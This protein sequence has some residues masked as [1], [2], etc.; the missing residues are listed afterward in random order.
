MITYHSITY[1]QTRRVITYT[2]IALKH[3]AIKREK[4]L[5]GENIMLHTS[6][7]NLFK[8]TKH[9]EYCNVIVFLMDTKS[10]RPLAGEK[11]FIFFLYEQSHIILTKS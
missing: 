10:R 4:G 8:V 7:F 9:K 11:Q 5:S 2:W 1:I 6:F 3:L